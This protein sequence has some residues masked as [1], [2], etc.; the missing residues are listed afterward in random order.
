[1]WSVERSTD[2]R[3]DLFILSEL[4]HSG[5]WPKVLAVPD[6]AYYG[7]IELPMTLL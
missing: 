4:M 2:E 3:K 7:E 6:T 5:D 1:M